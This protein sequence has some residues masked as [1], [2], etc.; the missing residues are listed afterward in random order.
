MK[1][2]TLFIV[3]LTILLAGCDTDVAFNT[4]DAEVTST[5][6]SIADF[7][8]PA[9]YRPEFTVSLEGYTL[10]A[11]K[12]GDDHSH[13]YLIQSKN[14]A[15]SQKLSQGLNELVPG[16]SDPQS[17]MTVL[18]TT[19]VSVRGKE[20]ALV[21]SEGINGDGVLYRQAMLAFEGK[22]GPAMLAFSEPVSIWNPDR[23][24]TLVSSIH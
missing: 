14:P 9:G 5:A 7:D 2:K 23:V 17:R 20:A 10:A 11:F 16:K 24:E 22:A 12:P 21:I 3:L 4:K 6:A 8:L 1:T 18:E 19:T 15:D 13:L